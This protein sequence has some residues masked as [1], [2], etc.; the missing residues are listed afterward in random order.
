MS[1]TLSASVRRQIIEF[2]PG[3]PDSLSISQLCDQ[4]GISRP[5]YYKVKKRYIA[6]GNKALNPHSRAP[7]SPAR[8]YGEPTKELVLR[9]RQR[10]AKA[11]WDHGPQSIWFEGV[12]SGEFGDQVPS[13]ATIGRILAESGVTKTNPRKRP[14][15]AWMRF[16]RSYPMEMWQLDGLEYRLFDQDG[17]KATIY[18]L[19]DDGTRFDVGSLCFERPEN[20]EDAI[21]TLRAAFDEYGVP[22]ELLT[23]NGL[24]FNQARRGKISSTE[25]FLAE[26]GCRGITGRIW[27]PET[28]GKNE[29]SHQTLVRFLDAHA[30]KNLD[31]LSKLLVR[32]REHY[33]YRRRHQSLKVGST[34]LTPG[35][36]WEAGEHRGSDGTPIGIEQLQAKADAYRDKQIALKAAASST[37]TG[38]TIMATQ[39]QAQEALPVQTGKLQDQPSDLVQITRTNPQIYYRGRAFKVPTHLVGEHRLVTTETGFTLFSTLDG[40][41]SLYFPLPLRLASSKKLMPLWQ[42]HGARI[43]EPRPAWVLKRID[44]EKQHYQLELTG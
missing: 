44:Y 16:S 43:R 14:R 35:Q 8:T 42:V 38:G 3:L 18:Q 2:D 30:P 21:S 6:E 31:D 40:E 22:Q 11:G 23:D 9:I 33:N 32:F 24:S 27:H 4:L 34:H 25:I 12:D 17:T 13:V 7:K 29:R 36:A 19:L 39:Q 15:S 5:S 41:E 20:S 26:R 10:M 28:Q 37:D 1:N